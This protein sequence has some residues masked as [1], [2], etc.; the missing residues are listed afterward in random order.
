MVVQEF[1]R[2]PVHA[3]HLPPVLLVELGDERIREERDV[4]RPPPQRGQR[5]RQHV[6]PVVE[7]LAERA[8]LHRLHHVLVGG[9]HHAHVDADLV[10]AAHAPHLA[11]L[12]DAKVLRLQV[13]AHLRDL[14][15]EDR[16][17]VGQLE[18]AG[19]AGHRSGERALLVTEQL[20]LEQGLRNGRAV[21]RHERPLRPLRHLV[22]GAGH[23]LLAGAGLP[24]DQHGGG[25]GCGHL[26]EAVNLLHRGA[27][28]EER[29]E[30]AALLELPA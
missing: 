23:Q 1:E 22:D 28:P 27:H 9:R 21:H 30:P 5:D 11:V 2:R 14:V 25:A 7:I 26:D 6:D 15:Q 18:I 16:A 3:P 19:P 17:A 20:A 29:P 10:V 24:H 13:R 4:L 12:E 8:L